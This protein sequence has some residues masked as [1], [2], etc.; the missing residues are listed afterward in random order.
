MA[1]ADRDRIVPNLRSLLAIPTETA[2]GSLKITA[3][4]YFTLVF[5]WL[6]TPFTERDIRFRK[7]GW[8]VG[9]YGPEEMM[10]NIRPG[11]R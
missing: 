9:R 6:C 3:V 10:W 5:A 7:A 11:S 2:E 8:K 1:F 4:V